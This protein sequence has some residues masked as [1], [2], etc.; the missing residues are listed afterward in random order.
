MRCT[1]RFPVTDLAACGTAIEVSVGEKG[2]SPILSVFKLYYGELVS[3]AARGP[4]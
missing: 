3:Q 1:Q 2:T 4:K